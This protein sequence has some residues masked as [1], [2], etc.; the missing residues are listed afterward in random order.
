[1]NASTKMTKTDGEYRIRLFIDG[2]YQ[3]G[4][5]YFTDDQ[6]D[7]IKTAALM[8]ENAGYSDKTTDFAK[9]E[10]AEYEDSDLIKR[11]EEEAKEKTIAFHAAEI[12]RLSNGK[13]KAIDILDIATDGIES[14]INEE[15]KIGCF[16][17]H[18]PNESEKVAIFNECGE[19]GDFVLADL[20]KVVS[21][22]F[23][24]NF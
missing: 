5:D 10:Q 13:A 8:L 17:V 7:A 3:A 14:I 22:F 1:M 4:A 16:T 9:D 6:Q 15:I 11:V 23:Y 18:P 20:E 12:E 19:G 24:K 21:D 2:N